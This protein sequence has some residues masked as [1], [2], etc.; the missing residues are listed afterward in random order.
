MSWLMK[1]IITKELTTLIFISSYCTYR[2][3]GFVRLEINLQYSRCYLL[4][5]MVIR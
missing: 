4:K 3:G 5:V 2:E 1:C